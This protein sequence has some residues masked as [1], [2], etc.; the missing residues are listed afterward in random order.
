MKILD[1]HIWC[2]CED[3]E[4]ALESLYS[5]SPRMEL[6]KNDWHRNQIRLKC[7]KCNRTIYVELSC[8]ISVKKKVKEE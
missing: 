5:Q 1:M 7:P 4:K 8:G 2:D 3:D 6:V